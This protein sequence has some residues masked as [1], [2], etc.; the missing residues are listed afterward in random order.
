MMALTLPTG[1]VEFLTRKH[2]RIWSSSVQGDEY[3]LRLIAESELD[4]PLGVLRLHRVV[5]SDL[6]DR[7]GSPLLCAVTYG[8]VND[9]SDDQRER[10]GGLRFD[11]NSRVLLLMTPEEVPL[12]FIHAGLDFSF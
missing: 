1:L 4:S 7:R 9:L 5:A 2:P 8:T 12:F 11:Q 6:M 3:E 10:I